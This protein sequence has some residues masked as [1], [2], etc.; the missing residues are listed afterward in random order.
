MSRS[1]LL[2]A[3]LI[4]T[5]GLAAPPRAL[6]QS[7]SP[8]I[9]I[10][11]PSTIFPVNQPVTFRYTDAQGAG[12]ITFTDLGLDQVTSFDLL[13]ASITQNGVTYNG[14]GIATVIPG[15]ARPLTD[16]VSFTVVSPTGVAY[17]FEGKMGLGV[18]FQ[19]SGT[20]HPVSDPTQIAS[21]GLLFVPG[22]PAPG[23]AALTLSLDRGCGSTYPAGGP[24]VIT[25]SSSVNDTL[26]LIDQRS[27]GTF[28]IFAN[29]PVIAGRMYSIST[30]VS[31]VPGPRTLILRDTAG[32]QAVCTFTGVTPT[33]A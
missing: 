19:G 2:L 13:R 11:A 17:F 22:P 21:W 12:S 16:L 6:A 32:V 14:S 25:Y 4:G 5:L 29:Q 3:A 15:A 31:T 18:E 26:T 7:P 23:P 33:P 28:A 20:Y 1:F 30:F 8:N 10:P 9:P 27:D 24:M